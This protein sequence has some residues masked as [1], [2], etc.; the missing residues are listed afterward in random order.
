MSHIQTEMEQIQL[1]LTGTSS[2]VSVQC[3]ECNLQHGQDVH[4]QMFNF[5]CIVEMCVVATA[6]CVLELP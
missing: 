2:F 6:S 1:L 3:A 4:C 5:S